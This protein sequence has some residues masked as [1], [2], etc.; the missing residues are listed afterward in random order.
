MMAQNKSVK[1]YYDNGELK[2]ETHRNDDGNIDYEKVFGPNGKLKVHVKYLENSK[3]KEILLFQESGNLER[4]MV[5]EGMDVECRKDYD[6]KGKLIDEMKMQKNGNPEW[7]KTYSKEEL[8]SEMDF[9]E[10]GNLKAEKKYDNNSVISENNFHENGVIHQAKFYHE[11]G[12]LRLEISYQRN[13]N[14]DWQKSY[15]SNGVLK[16]ETHH[17]IDGKTD[18]QRS[19][20]KKGVEI[21]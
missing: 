2:E 18:S 10:N 5:L 4:E 20:D 1:E 15:H 11:N 12:Q 21:L 14:P 8:T 3:R 17:N 7:R 13:G 16:T 6:K 19:Y 9:H